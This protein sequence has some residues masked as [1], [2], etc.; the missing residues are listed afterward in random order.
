MSWTS[1]SSREGLS[2][3]TTPPAPSLENPPE[4]LFPMGVSE[5]SRTRGAERLLQPPRHQGRRTLQALAPLAPTAP[6]WGPRSRSQGPRGGTWCPDGEFA[7][8]P[9]WARCQAGEEWWLPPAN[10]AGIF[11]SGR[12]GRESKRWLPKTAGGDAPKLL[13][14]R[15]SPRPPPLPAFLWKVAQIHKYP[16]PKAE[17]RV[18]TYFVLVEVGPI[19]REASSQDPS[20]TSRLALDH[21]SLS[22]GCRE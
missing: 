16:P 19:G 2:F 13:R 21:P 15:G 18:V 4:N 8:K 17:T 3:P 11:W 6:L 5:A 22:S 7:Q 14:S 12:C 10:T 9:G 1:P 20:L